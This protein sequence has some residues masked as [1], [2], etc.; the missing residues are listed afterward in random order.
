MPSLITQKNASDDLKFISQAPGQSL[1]S[2][3]GYIY[4]KD[5]EKRSKP[6]VYV[7]DTGAEFDHPV[8]ILSLFVT[9]FSTS[10]HR[11]IPSCPIQEFDR[12]RADWEWIFPFPQYA[13]V[14]G[15]SS[16]H[17]TV[18]LSKVAGQR[19]GVARNVKAIIVKVPSG[20]EIPQDIATPTAEYWVAAVERVRDDFA[21]RRAR[22][23][24]DETRTAVVSMSICITEAKNKITD[25]HKDRLKAAL[26]DL[27][28]FGALPIAGTGN[29]GNAIPITGWPAKF[30]EDND[31]QGFLL[32]SGV[33]LNGALWNW[34]QTADYVDV[35]APS[36]SIYA[37]RSYKTSPLERYAMGSGTSEACAMVSGLAV[38]FQQIKS[39]ET[40]LGIGDESITPKDRVIALKNHIVNASWRRLDDGRKDETNRRPNAV[41]NSVVGKP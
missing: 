7:V 4:D 13:G 24:Y 17:G 25:D 12:I 38:Y 33:E 14:P 1:H 32:V 21:Q 18:M 27:I 9:N 2:L 26:R 5:A 3:K 36:N 15:E 37:A 34:S 41:C 8:G 30:S 20:L 35:F 16:G 11:L 28:D 29:D 23:D 10:Q 19:V 39:L 22:P 40:T 31:L 6:V